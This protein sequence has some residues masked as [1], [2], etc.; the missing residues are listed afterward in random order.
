MAAFE[1]HICL[2][3]MNVPYILT[4]PCGM[5]N[6]MQSTTLCWTGNARRADVSS[7][8]R[9]RTEETGLWHTDL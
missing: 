6:A 9:N 5:L 1:R 2:L 3:I 4:L 7:L 8:E